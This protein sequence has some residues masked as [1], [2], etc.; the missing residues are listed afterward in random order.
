MTESRTNTDSTI[1]TNTDTTDTDSGIEINIDNY[2]AAVS[3]QTIEFESNCIYKKNKN[4]AFALRLKPIVGGNFGNYLCENIDLLVHIPLKTYY[5]KN[6]NN[7]NVFPE[8]G[9]DVW[10]WSYVNETSKDVREFIIWAVDIGNIFIEITNPIEP[11]LIGSIPSAISAFVR[12][13]K[14]LGNFAYMIDDNV[15]GDF[16]TEG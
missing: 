14:V 6:K 10:G 15:A 7:R 5:I 8:E 3:A 12:D 16:N 9:S 11:I 13:V 2:I 4:Q 1:D